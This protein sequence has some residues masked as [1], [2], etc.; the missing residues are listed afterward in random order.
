MNRA[1][2]AVSTVLVALAAQASELFAQ[3]Q[4]VTVNATADAWVS[5]FYPN[6]ISPQPGDN[7]VGYDPAYGKERVFVS[8]SLPALP[9]HAIVTEARLWA[10]VGYTSSSSS[11][12]VAACQAAQPWVE[13][14]V[15]WNTQ[16]LFTNYSWS[17]V[18]GAT[19]W[20]GWDATASVLEWYGGVSP[21]YGFILISDELSAVLNDRG[22]AD[23]TTGATFQL[24][25][26]YLLPSVSYGT[27]E[28]EYVAGMNNGPTA[29]CVNLVFL[30]DGFSGDSEL[31]IFKNTTD[32]I[33]ATM[34]STPPFQGLASRFNVYRVNTKSY[35]SGI[36][37][38]EFDTWSTAFDS[39]LYDLGN[40]S[41][42]IEVPPDRWDTTVTSAKAK[43]PACDVIVILT[44]TTASTDLGRAW[45]MPYWPT[46]SYGYRACTAYTGANVGR[47]V[48]HEL[49]HALGTVGD[50]YDNGG[51]LA[52]WPNLSLDGGTSSVKWSKWVGLGDVQNP[53]SFG[54]NG[55][56]K[57]VANDK[58]IMNNPWISTPFCYVCDE[59]VG[60]RV[61]SF[62]RLSGA[63]TENFSAPAGTFS[64]TAGDPSLRWAADGTPGSVTG[65]A[66]RSGPNSLNYNNG[67]DYSNGSLNRGSVTLSTIVQTGNTDFR[68]W[69]NRDTENVDGKDRRFLKIMSQGSDGVLTEVYSKEFLT[70]DCPAGVWHEHAVTLAGWWGAVQPRFFFDTVDANAN[71]TGGWFID[72]ISATPLPKTGGGKGGGGGGCGL[73]GLEGP[74][75]LAL[76]AL[77][78]R[79][80]R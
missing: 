9:P 71:A 25:V 78:G 56:Y 3:A 23:R 19:G 30:A 27:P 5:S 46:G 38:S 40:G 70:A 36:R 8:F 7:W 53:V 24:D 79:R 65:G 74:L 39:Y 52:F 54:S 32:S 69:C 66:S 6:S 18:P 44:N 72:D 45:L 59:H 41:S 34:F 80:R 47:V 29:Q 48:M 75:L 33:V 62:R 26:F 50:E 20:A 35:D 68:F 10:Y 43:V 42:R 57:P 64:A 11:L 63:V 17:T 60:A 22:I 28:W 77:A 14:A 37:L 58:C 1:A 51:A 76:V 67:S 16:P 73:T 2:L 15:T 31:Q 12:N 55:L 4:T 13:G 49:G 61:M 21:N